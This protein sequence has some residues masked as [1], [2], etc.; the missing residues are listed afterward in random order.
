MRAMTKSAAIELAPFNIRVNSIHPALIRTPMTS[1]HPSAE[2]VL[3][4][5]A[6][7]TPAKRLDEPDEIASIVLLLGIG[8]I[9]IL[10][11]RRICC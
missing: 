1:S 4:T 3:A 8:R 2:Q 6:A 9:A 7:V 5:L 10:Y 11:W